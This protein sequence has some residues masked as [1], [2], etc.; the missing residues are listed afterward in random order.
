MLTAVS[1]L[2][3]IRREIKQMRDG[4]GLSL[5]KIQAQPRYEG[6]SIASIDRIYHGQEPGP[7]V[8]A[9]LGLPQIGTVIVIGGGSIPAGA[10]VVRAELCKCGEWFISNHPRR[11]KCF[12]CSPFRRRAKK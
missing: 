7:K 5:R 10:Q 2:D 4:D 9:A 8:R 1:A 3:E 12:V 11:K 6:I